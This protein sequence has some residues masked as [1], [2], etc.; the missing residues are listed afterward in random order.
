MAP[1]LGLVNALPKNATI[2]YVG[3]Q[4]VFEGDEGES[5]EQK[6]IRERGIRFIPLKSGRVQRALTRQTI[7]SLLKVPRG[8]AQAVAIL[9][10]EKPDVV[11]GFGGYLSVPMGFAA[12]LLHIPLIIHESTLGAGLANKILAPFAQKICISWDSSRAFFP[13]NKTIVTGNPLLPFRTNAKQ[14]PLPASKE[15]LPLIVVSGGS[16]GSHMV[17]IR[18]AHILPEL[19]EIARVVHQTGDAKAFKDYDMLLAK[20]HTLSKKLQNRYFLVKFISP[21]DM[22]SVFAAADL[23]VGRSGIN[24]VAALL[25]LQKRALLIPLL[26]GQKNEQLQNAQ[27]MESEG[28]AHIVDQ[29]ELSAKTLF[30]SIREM[31]LFKNPG[32]V[33]WHIPVI[34]KG[35]ENLTKEVLQCVKSHKEK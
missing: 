10:K 11:V 31:L 16:G 22:N 19:L 27:L 33:K 7:P 32:K 24:T 17:N 13:E 21:E 28:L 6:T 14:L 25:I 26:V 18:I 23:V 5:L 30:Q 2:V 3:R 8:F 1:A 20:K 29:H 12:R 15:H 4:H 35:A 34:Q 9:H